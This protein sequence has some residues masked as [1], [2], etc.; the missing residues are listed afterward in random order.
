MNTC[1]FVSCQNVS[2]AWKGIGS[3]VELRVFHKFE[4]IIKGFWSQDY[5]GER[6]I[7]KTLSEIQIL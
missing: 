3:Y 2:E 4:E 5:F 7:N 1:S 6:L